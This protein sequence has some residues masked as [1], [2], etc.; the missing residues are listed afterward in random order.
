MRPLALL[1]ILLL[2]V[3]PPLSSIMGVGG[4]QTAWAAIDAACPWLVLLTILLSLRVAWPVRAVGGV[5]L[6]TLAVLNAVDARFAYISL[7]ALCAGWLAVS[8]AWFNSPQTANR[9]QGRRDDH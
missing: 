1:T 6:V 5:G 8:L 4:K 3:L 7:A 2:V 9:P